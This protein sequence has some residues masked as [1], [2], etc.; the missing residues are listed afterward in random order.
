MPSTRLLGP[1]SCL[2]AQGLLPVRRVP[3]PRGLLS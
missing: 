1:L 2:K 3:S